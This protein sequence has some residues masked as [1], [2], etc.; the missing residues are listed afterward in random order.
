QRMAF[1][2]GAELDPAFRIEIADRYRMHLARHDRIV[3]PRAAALD[4]PP[5]LA[6]R[7]GEPG[8]YKQLESRHAALPRI[9]RDLNLQQLTASAARLEHLA[10]GIGRGVR[11]GAAMRQRGRL[12]GQHLLSLVA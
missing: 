7:G 9:S 11:G 6:V 1:P 4:Q 2:A 8:A 12:G 5:R 3:E 10:R